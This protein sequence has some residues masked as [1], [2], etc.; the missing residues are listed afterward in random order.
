MIKKKKKERGLGRSA[1]NIVRTNDVVFVLP[2]FRTLINECQ[3]GI[4]SKSLE[5]YARYVF[6]PLRLVLVC[7]NKI[8]PGWFSSMTLF[9]YSSGG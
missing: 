3:I 9:S 2:S 4:L 7:C 5:F 6:V 1:I 8:Q